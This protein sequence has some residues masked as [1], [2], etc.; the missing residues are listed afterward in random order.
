MPYIFR[1][2]PLFYFLLCFYSVCC[3]FLSSFY[4]NWHYI[5]SWSVSHPI[6][7]GVDFLHLPCLKNALMHLLMVYSKDIMVPVLAYGQIEA[8]EERK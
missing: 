8:A 1:F 2:Y 5:F 4:T 7:S 3:G 6:A